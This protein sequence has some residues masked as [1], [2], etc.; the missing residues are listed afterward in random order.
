MSTGKALQP[1][2]QMCGGGRWER[3]KPIAAFSLEGWQL[4]ALRNTA[5]ETGRPVS[6]VL[7]AILAENLQP[8]G[9]GVLTHTP[10]RV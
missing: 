4:E 1:P 8:Q 7:R 9:A 3:K 10:L 2:P 6:A 5:N